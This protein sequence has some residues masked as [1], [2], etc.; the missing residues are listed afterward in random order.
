M[1]KG[2]KVS[3]V[4]LIAGLTFLSMASSPAIA[5]PT[6]IH[7]SYT[8]QIGG[9]EDLTLVLNAFGFPDEELEWNGKL[10][11]PESS[12]LPAGE[13]TLTIDPDPYSTDIS[14]YHVMTSGSITDSTNPEVIGATFHLHATE[15]FMRLYFTGPGLILNL[16]DLTWGATQVI[17]KA[18]Y[19]QVL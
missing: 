14:Y 7:I 13:S 5:R 17:V 15:N 11:I 6:V 9:M 3:L 1:K 16:A 18:D 19:G 12:D 8:S 4:V 2:L 10:V